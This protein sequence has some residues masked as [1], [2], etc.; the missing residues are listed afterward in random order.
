MCTVDTGTLCYTGSLVSNL[1]RFESSISLRTVLKQWSDSNVT[2]EWIIL[3][4]QT[5]YQQLLSNVS[6]STNPQLNSVVPTGNTSIQLELSYNIPYNVSVTQNTVCHQLI[7]TK[8]LLLNYSKLLGCTLYIK[9][10]INL[11][12]S[13][14]V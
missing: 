14:Q 8:V 12:C 5:Y 2:L 1:I 3:S 7:Q 9:I 4:S 13:R 10:N 11:F 6:V